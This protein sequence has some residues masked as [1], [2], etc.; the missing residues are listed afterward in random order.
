MI[1][2]LAGGLLLTALVTGALWRVWGAPVLLPA[3]T[4]GLVATTVQVASA[5]LVRRVAKGEFKLLVRRWGMGMGLRA[6]GIALFG[7]ASWFMPERFPPLPTA[8]AYL[9]VVVP[10]LFLEIRFLK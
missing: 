4:F 2:A 3:V 7:G 5:A 10:L 6:L 9:G 8:F 1:V